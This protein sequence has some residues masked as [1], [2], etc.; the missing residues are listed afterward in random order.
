MRPIYSDP[1]SKIVSGAGGGA[2]VSSR[3]SEAVT[4]LRF[5]EA[6]LDFLIQYR[7]GDI[8]EES[9]KAISELLHPSK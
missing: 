2:A 6:F 4:K 7:K 9:V 1:E 3:E 8:S 5:Y